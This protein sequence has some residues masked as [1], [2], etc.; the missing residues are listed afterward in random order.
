MFECARGGLCYGFGESGGTPIGNQDRRR[1]SG[2]RRSHDRAQVV[3][4]FHAIQ[5]HQQLRPF[6]YLVELGITLRGAKSHDALMRGAIRSAIER[7]ARFEADRHGMLAGEI[8]NLLYPWTACAPGDQYPVERSSGAKGFAYGMNTGQ[9]ASVAFGV[10]R[11]RTRR[12][13]RWAFRSYQ[14]KGRWPLIEWPHY[15][16][17]RG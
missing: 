5:Y 11:R 9:N 17:A 13:M 4:I 15:V 1:A 2:M 3:W 6:Q 12:R 14:C 16:R 8:H 10:G 7:I